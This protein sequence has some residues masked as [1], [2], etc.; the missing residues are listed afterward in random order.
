MRK[1]TAAEYDALLLDLDVD[2]ETGVVFWNKTVTS[3]AV[4]GAAAGAVCSTTG[5]LMIGHRK[6]Y[7]LAHRVVYYKATGVLPDM[8]DHMDGVRTN[9]AL[10][11]L[12]PASYRVNNANIHSSRGKLQGTTY[13]ASR[14]KW[15]AAIRIGEK[16]VNLGRFDTAEQAH[17]VYVEAKRKHHVGCEH[18]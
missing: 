4:I 7:F 18:W 10:A 8:L 17:A 1:R 11:N 16:S 15:K 2:V 13:E 6:K 14:G 5:Y 3:R 12:R 9:N